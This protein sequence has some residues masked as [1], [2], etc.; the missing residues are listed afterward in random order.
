MRKES[1]LGCLSFLAWLLFLLV[2]PVLDFSSSVVDLSSAGPDMNYALWL[3]FIFALSLFRITF[4]FLFNLWWTFK[5]FFQLSKENPFWNH[6]YRG[7]ASIIIL[8][9][10]FIL[11]TTIELPHDIK[12]PLVIVIWSTQYCCGILWPF[13]LCWNCKE[14]VFV[15][16][17]VEHNSSSGIK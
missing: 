7:V 17:F 8:A 2:N 16:Y 14:I 1:E 9:L 3:G 11:C 5:I 15:C 6:C 13:T 10:N 4:S 12:G